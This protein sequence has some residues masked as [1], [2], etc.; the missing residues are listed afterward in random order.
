ML[1]NTEGAIKKWTIQRN[2]QHWV[3]K[4]QDENKQ[5][6]KHHYA[7]TNINSVNKTWTLLQTTGGKDEHNIVST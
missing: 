3:H 2:G 6:K 5:N 7:Q 4:T 1:E